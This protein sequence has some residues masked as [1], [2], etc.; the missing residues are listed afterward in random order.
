MLPTGDPQ[1]P[2]CEPLDVLG[3]ILGLDF[4]EHF[5]AAHLLINAWFSHSS[6]PTEHSTQNP[7][8]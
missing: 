1:K 3:E 7:K 4:Q 5:N 8:Q 2:E 6:V